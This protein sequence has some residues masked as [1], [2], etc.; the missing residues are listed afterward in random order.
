M[1]GRSDLYAAEHHWGDALVDVRSH[2]LPALKIRFLLQHLPA[3]GKVLEVG[4]GGGRLLNTVAAH[5]PGLELYGCDI[6]ALRYQPRRFAFSMVDPGASALPYA[7][8][9]FDAVV[10]FDVL[11]H[12]IAPDVSLRA[13]R[14]ALKPGGRLIS[15]TPLEGQR[16][17]FYRAYRRLL[18]DDLYATTKEHVHAFSEVSL[19]RLVLR[20][21]RFLDHA[22]AYH[23]TGQFMDATLFA[24]LKSERLRARF[25]TDN[26]FYRETQSRRGNPKTSILSWLLRAANALA[27]RE[28]RLLRR[29]AF[30]SAGLLF[31]ASRR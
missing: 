12:V 1:L 20:D 10:M 17:S 7:A 27:Y 8:E 26:P 29:I 28:S 11:E 16:L 25:W 22:Y 3:H 19:R 4:C 14:T 18:G 21:F 30:G 2:D 31:V 5:R 13:V 15:F 24:M 23:I 9:T 6:R